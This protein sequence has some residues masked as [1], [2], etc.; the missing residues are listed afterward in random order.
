MWY[1]NQMGKFEAIIH[2][3]EGFEGEQLHES[4]GAHPTVETAKEALYRLCTKTPMGKI[5]WID[6]LVVI[7][8]LS[9]KVEIE[10]K[11]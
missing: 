1:N 7:H 8:K 11:L 9:G 4:A 3:R 10:V 5:A 2:F 6:R